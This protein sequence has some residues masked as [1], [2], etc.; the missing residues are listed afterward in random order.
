MCVCVCVYIHIHTYIK[1]VGAYRGSTA[2]PPRL[3]PAPYTY[4]NSN[5]HNTCIEI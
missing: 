1:Y 4:V 2:N 5:L 3:P